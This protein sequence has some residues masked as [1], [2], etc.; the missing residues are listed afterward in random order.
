MQENNMKRAL[1]SEWIDS[2][3]YV[4]TS[5]QDSHGFIGTHH[6]LKHHL[7]WWRYK[8]I[9]VPVGWVLHHKDEDKT[10]NHLSNLELMTV[11]AHTRLHTL[12]RKWPEEV[13]RKISES[14]KKNWEN[15]LK[16]KQAMSKR[17]RKLWKQPKLRAIMRSHPP[18]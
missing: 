2:L 7:I 12:G 14:A 8:K 5:I 15:N 9:K 13:K 16:R 4:W 10:N 3:G 11:A 18:K 17:I 6:V 1:G